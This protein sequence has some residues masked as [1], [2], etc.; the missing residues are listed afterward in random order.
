MQCTV[1]ITNFKIVL[2]NNNLK[3][4]INKQVL[5]RRKN[6]FFTILIG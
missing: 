4:N 1:C 5:L 6:Y 3:I 2:E